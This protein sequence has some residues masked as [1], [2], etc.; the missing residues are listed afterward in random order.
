MNPRKMKR[1]MVSKRQ[2]AIA[3]IIGAV[4]LLVVFALVALCI[5]PVK[6][7]VSEGEAAPA[8][9]AAS[10]D[11]TDT[12]STDAATQAA[13]DA[14]SLMY[15][16][17][18]AV[19]TQ[20]KSEISAYF[21]D[22]VVASEYIKEKYI[23]AEV[24]SLSYFVARDV[25]EQRY[26]PTQ[27]DWREFFNGV[28]I[29]EIRAMIGAED[30]SDEL[31]YAL[32]ALDE[33]ALLNIKDD[34]KDI[35][36]VSLDNGIQQEH[37]Q[38]EIDGIRREIEALYPDAYIGDLAL[39]P[40]DTYLSANM[41]FDEEATEQARQMVQQDVA[42]VVYK[43]SQTIVVQDDIVSAAQMK[44]LQELGVVGGEGADYKLYIGMFVFILLLFGV[45]GTYMYQ[46][47]SET[48][49]ETRKLL[50][51]ATIVVVV[52]AISVPLARLDY[53]ILPVFFGTMLVS[54]LVGRKS[55]LALGVLL[56]FV[57][58][59]ISS[60]S[61]GILSVTMLRTVMMTIIGGSVSVFALYKPGH[62]TALIFSG[63]VAGLVSVLIAV[64]INMVGSAQ[65]AAGSL[66]QDSAYALG[67]GLLAGVLAIGT[68]P[69]WEA[70][71]RVSTPTK[72]LELSN[73]NHP[74]LKRLTIEA[75]GTYHHS[76]L[77][78]NLAEAGADAIGANALLCRVGAYY[79]DVGKL[80][81]PRYFKENQKGDNPHDELPPSVSAKIITDHLT[82]GLDYAQK[83]K[84][85]RDVQK[86]IAQHHGNTTVAYFL[87]K[88]KESGEKVNEAA[89][90]YAGSKPSTKES[91]VVMLADTVEAAVRS[92]DDPDK[93]Q[94]KDMINQLIRT[95]YN[96]GQLDEC[97]L[98]RRDLNTI[99]KAFLTTFEGAFH[100]RV[101]Y[102]GQE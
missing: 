27:I 57:A 41:I 63:L 35:V 39:V 88:A 79:H 12:I 11:I 15:T 1:R 71:F 3:I 34:V 55:A 81:G 73:P 68:L 48:L 16:V 99:A 49:S 30:I 87:H 32:A 89:F 52:V 37:V 60:W 72:L 51:I 40:V 94:V 26:D 6:Y 18:D 82:D 65:I 23:D 25:L 17:D 92:M 59:A 38:T 4:T 2:A 43:Q 67:S 90:R 96:D 56:A 91:A 8:T 95:R 45:Y 93:E 47:E 86:V 46:F 53:R 5:T 13:R 80:E 20:V 29:S 77:T 36:A 70:I 19:S 9:I 102:P 84:L 44:V 14:V 75:P 61:T 78:A 64:L 42:D 85:P 24:A 100:D 10:R 54:V 69:I 31:V 74:L 83:Y 98:N 97:P 50:I 7:E 21:E 76:I 62:R 101:K 28:Q 22:L 58:G 33:A 66:W